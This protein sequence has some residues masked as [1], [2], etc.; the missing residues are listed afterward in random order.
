M[1][2]GKDI[3]KVTINKVASLKAEGVP[4]KSIGRILKGEFSTSLSSVY[5][6]QKQEDSTGSVAP[7]RQRLLLLC[8]SI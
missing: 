4:I 7:K 2:K 5:E 3:R 8:S 6:W 1:T